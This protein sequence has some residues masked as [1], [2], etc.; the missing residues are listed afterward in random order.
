MSRRTRKTTFPH[1][2]VLSPLATSPQP[3]RWQILS[4]PEVA[5]SPLLRSRRAGRTW[6]PSASPLLGCS[7]AAPCCWQF[8]K[9]WEELKRKP[10]APG[11]IWLTSAKLNLRRDRR[12]I[13]TDGCVNGQTMRTRISFVDF[14]PKKKQEMKKWELKPGGYRAPCHTSSSSTAKS[15]YWTEEMETSMFKAESLGHYNS[16]PGNIFL[17]SGLKAFSLAKRFG[18]CIC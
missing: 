8:S 18:N 1:I 16:Y 5:A 6:V 2:C 7:M 10:L 15:R 3:T 14:C 4:H 11:K 13:R 9:T 12:S 17:N